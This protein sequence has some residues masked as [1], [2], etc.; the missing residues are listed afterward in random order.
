MIRSLAVAMTLALVVAPAFA[1]DS[2]PPLVTA[3]QVEGSVQVN[4]GNGFAPLREDQV[5]Q[6]GDRVMAMGGGEAT[7]TFSDGCKLEVEEETIVTVPEESTCTGGIATV[8]T[9]APASTGAVGGTAA[10]GVDW[11]GFWTIAG[12]V[13]IGDAILFAEDDGDTVSP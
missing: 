8:Q 13:I 11:K 4:T 12:I 10:G 9:I 6:P 3:T 7:L 5:L 1:Q 2:P